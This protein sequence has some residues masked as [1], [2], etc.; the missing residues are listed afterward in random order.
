MELTGRWGRLVV[1]AHSDRRL[2]RHG[3]QRGGD[4]QQEGRE[5]EVEQPLHV[6]VGCDVA[7]GE[8]GNMSS[9]G[10]KV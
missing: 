4:G 7:G 9:S 10:M 6:L 8:K 5:W 1:L 3:L 2:R